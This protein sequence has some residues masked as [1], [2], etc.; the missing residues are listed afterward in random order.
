MFKIC[1][2][3][4]KKNKNFKNLNKLFCEVKISKEKNKM[5]SILDPTGNYWTIPHQFFCN[6]KISD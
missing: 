3:S 6:L 4:S 2:I 1:P 5:G